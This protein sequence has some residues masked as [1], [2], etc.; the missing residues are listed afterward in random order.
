MIGRGAMGRPWIVGQIE[1]ELAG[2]RFTPPDLAAQISHLKAQIADSVALY[3][4][5]L[6]LRIVRKHI[7]AW[8]EKAY[9]PMS[10]GEARKFRSELC[11]MVE[12]EKI[13]ERLDGLLHER[14]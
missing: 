1:A 4:E 7:S 13:F 5:H 10:A 3:R 8:V 2:Q 14:V 9:L 12:A 11:Q 6:G